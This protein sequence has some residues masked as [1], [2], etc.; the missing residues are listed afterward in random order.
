M[1]TMD[2]DSI[3]AC[4]N[5][6]LPRCDLKLLATSWRLVTASTRMCDL[7]IQTNNS[8]TGYWFVAD[9]DAHINDA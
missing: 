2:T 8:V 3:T 5:E 4:S 7:Y 9:L 1:T 6:Q